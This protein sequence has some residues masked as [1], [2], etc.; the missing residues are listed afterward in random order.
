MSLS[1]DGV[2]ACL[3]L[4]RGGTENCVE[5]LKQNRTKVEQADRLRCINFVVLVSTA[6]SKKMKLSRLARISR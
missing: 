4:V 1:K 5:N 3:Q 6:T 2:G